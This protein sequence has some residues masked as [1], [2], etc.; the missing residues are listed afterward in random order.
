MILII[1]NSGN[2]RK[3]HSTPE[4]INFFKF[5]NIPHK[6]IS[7]SSKLNKILLLEKKKVKGIIL[8]GSDLK[9]TE[10][11]CTCKI[12]MNLICLL[13]FDIPILGI[14]FGFQT[15]GIA[16]GGKIKSLKK[17]RDKKVALNY[18]PHQIFKN[19]TKNSK[20][21]EYNSDYLSD[22]PILFRPIAYGDDNI[23]EAIEHYNRPIFGVQFH[24]ELSGKPGQH[25]LKNFIDICSN[26][27]S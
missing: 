4:L 22:L 23:L 2:L 5:N 1:N 14:C 7:N 21:Q 18:S 17:I 11:I 9:Y 26:Y 3:A 8:S 16:F 19:I 27:S 15:I 13:E 25:L 6:V 20:F 24:P 12:N 10:K